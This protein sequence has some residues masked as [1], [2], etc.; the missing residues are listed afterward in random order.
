VRMLHYEEAAG[1]ITGGN[2]EENGAESQRMG[3]VGIVLA[4][5]H[6][7]ESVYEWG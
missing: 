3:M 5:A 7:V 2:L 1:G 6:D 4:V